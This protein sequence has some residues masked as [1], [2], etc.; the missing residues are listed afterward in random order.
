[1]NGVMFKWIFALLDTPFFYAAVFYCR[2][3]LNIPDSRE[4]VADG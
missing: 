4:Q 1:M 2:R 3:R